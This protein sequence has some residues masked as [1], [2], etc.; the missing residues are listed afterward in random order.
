MKR[1]L[2]GSCHLE[3]SAGSPAHDA[4]GAGP[5][6]L[7]VM[8]VL[9]AS[10]YFAEQDRGEM[11]V[12]TRALKRVVVGILL[13]VGACGGGAK[14]PPGDP[15]LKN[16]DCTNPLSCGYGLCHVTCTEARDCPTGQDCVKAPAGNVCQLPVE[17]HC[18]YRSDCR[19]PLVCALDRQCRS[20][21]QADI[22][23][24]TPTQR[25]VG[26]TP[27]TV[28]AEPA[29]INAQT[30][31]LEK[32]LGTPVPAAPPDAGAGDGAPGDGGP[33]V[34]VGRAGGTVSGPGG[35]VVVPAGAL[36]QDQTLSIHVATSG[37]PALPAGAVL[38]SG[39]L[40]F[41]PHGQS[42]AV[43]V[44]MTVA[45]DPRPGTTPQL[46]TASPGGS[47][48]AVAGAMSDGASMRAMVAHFSFFAVIGLTS[49][50]GAD[51]VPVGDASG[52]GGAGHAGTACPSPETSFGLIGQGDSNPG[53]QSG[54]GA[55]GTNVMYIFSSD[56]VP[57]GDAGAQQFQ[58]YVQ[59]FDPKTG[60]SKGPSHPLFEAPT[61]GL[62]VPPGNTPFVVASAAVAPTGDIALLYYIQAV[63]PRG[64]ALYA[65][66]LSPSAAGAGADGG[67]DGLTLQNVVL[68]TDTYVYVTKP[69]EGNG[70]NT[71]R[72]FW[73]NASQTFVVSFQWGANL[74]TLNKFSVGGQMA[75]GR[76]PV[77]TLQAS[78][79]VGSYGVVG[80]SGTLLGVD[81]M[82]S[83]DHTGEVGLTLLDESG[84][85]V[86][87]PLLLAKGDTNLAWTGIAGTAQGFVCF[88]NQVGQQAAA[89][90]FV[91][92]SP[93]GGLVGADG[94]AA[95]AFPGFT[96]PGKAVDIRTI[97]DDVGKG[98][99]G[100][101]GVALVLDGGSVGFAYV[102]ADGLGHQGPYQALAHGGGKSS[103]SMTN[104]NG[105]FAISAY[106]GATGSTQVVAT[107]VCP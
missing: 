48:G 14:P 36:A 78:N 88:Y 96:L 19:A 17:T 28:C 82:G 30:K 80:E 32:S 21:C 107:G 69:S 50:G 22:D 11:N 87:G 100:G 59:A 38:L 99:K 43:P 84:N 95:S 64:G 65:A 77:P 62:S 76:G 13:L 34:I 74:V 55:L 42:F 79:G 7:A 4:G 57:V 24:P 51:D 52:D 20:Q 98:G 25:C 60:A 35:E 61:L 104:Y 9:G 92:T 86:G 53:F 46:I 54:V 75:G 90:V 105:S 81:Y 71:P 2:A 101:V 5:R 85:L 39:V 10:W 37:V 16:S 67:A 106:S 8:A 91:S 93:D 1:V 56:E 15:C 103:V 31:L 83:Q 68:V 45:F 47:W 89:E 3:R 102:S 73:S 23:C 6:G 26:S 49:D 33:G 12:S 70:D 27:D 40:A 72:V 63:G 58:I 41:E 97:A 94:G 44:T 29:E 66:F 18:D